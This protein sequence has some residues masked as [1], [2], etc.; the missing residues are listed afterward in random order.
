MK[1][2][3]LSE[4]NISLELY[5]RDFI[6]LR[7]LEPE[8]TDLPVIAKYI[9]KKEFAFVEETIATEKEICLKLN[10]KFNYSDLIKIS[11][12]EIDLVS[13][14]RNWILPVLFNT[15]PDWKRIS[16]HCRLSREAYI[17]QLCSH[18]LSMKMYGFIPGYVYLSGLSENLWCPRKEIP[19]K[20]VPANSFAVAEHY[21]GIYSLESPGGWNILGSLACPI[22]ALGELPP[23]MLDI[24]DTVKLRSI[25]QDEYEQIINRS[26]NILEYNGL[27]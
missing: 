25:S 8:N 14:T 19:A 3:K 15:G 27:T 12:L 6:L 18:D 17:D 22:I 13:N 23:V 7:T 9:Y 11:E 10:E 1:S 16:D 5:G 20:S 26:T 2:V 24:H 4:S 21:A